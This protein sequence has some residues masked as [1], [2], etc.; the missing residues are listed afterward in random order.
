MSDNDLSYFKEFKGKK[1]DADLEEQ[2][3]CEKK[4]WEELEGRWRMHYR[5]YYVKKDVFDQSKK[6]PRYNPLRIFLLFG[7]IALA[8]FGVQQSAAHRIHLRFYRSADNFFR[9][10]V[11]VSAAR[12]YDSIKTGYR[13]LQESVTNGRESSKRFALNGSVQDDEKGIMSD[14]EPDRGADLNS[15]DNLVRTASREPVSRGTEKETFYRIAERQENSHQMERAVLSTAIPERSADIYTEIDLSISADNR[16]TSISQEKADGTPLTTKI[17][18]SR[19]S[20][21]LITKEQVDRL[22]EIIKWMSEIRTLSVVI[23]G[24]AGDTFDSNYNNRLA[25]N[26]LKAAADY[27]MS[28]G[29]AKARISGNSVAR[30]QELYDSDIDSRSVV[31]EIR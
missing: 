14:M 2:A 15:R 9:E 27:L 25:K 12:V 31:F 24:Y 26:R 17:P 30:S 8:V 11:A 20:S 23:T 5:E 10:F 28:G 21:G 18:F 16:V 13:S 3:R 22:D 7:L 6:P 1:S 19:N 4:E 29:I